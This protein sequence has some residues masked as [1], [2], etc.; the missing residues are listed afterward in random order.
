[1]VLPTAKHHTKHFEL[2]LSK[3]FYIH[4]SF[5]VLQ[6]WRATNPPKV[7]DVK[8]IVP[9]RQPKPH[10]MQCLHGVHYKRVPQ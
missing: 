2:R 8:T 5:P 3:L 1:M 9:A 10:P 7:T 4:V 6:Y